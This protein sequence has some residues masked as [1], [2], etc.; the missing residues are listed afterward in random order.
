ME[1][2]LLDFP[3]FG[4]LQW[5]VILVAETAVVNAKKEANQNDTQVMCKWLL[6]IM[7]LTILKNQIP[8]N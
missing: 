7:A 6:L 8:V 2:S 1:F 4:T 5:L 3:L